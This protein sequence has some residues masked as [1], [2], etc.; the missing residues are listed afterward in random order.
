VVGG[1]EQERER[2]LEHLFHLAW[3]GDQFDRGG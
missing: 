1:I 2:H 3:V